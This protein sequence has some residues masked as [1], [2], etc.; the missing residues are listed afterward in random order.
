M[1]LAFVG[2]CLASDNGQIAWEHSP[3]K[4]FER[5]RTEKRCVILDLEAIWCHWCHV[6]DEKTYSDPR[7][8]KLLNEH[9]VALKVDQDS[10]P[11]FSNRYEEYGWPATILFGP[12]GKELVKRSGYIAPDDMVSLLEAIVRDPTPGP[13]AAPV[14]RIQYSGEGALSVDQ[15]RDLEEKHFARYDAKM[16]GWGTFHKFL[17]ADCVEYAMMR[18]AEGD[19]RSEKMARQTLDAQRKLIDPVWGGVYQYSTDGDWDHP[20]FEKIMSVQGDNLRIYAQAYAFWNEP[21]YLKAAQSIH[22]YLRDFM[23]SPDGVFYTSQD[24]DVVQGRHSGDYFKLG[25]QERRAQ[26]I[27]RIDTHVYA[28]ENGWAIQ[29]LCALYGATGDRTVRDEA[30]RAANW[31][32]AHRALPRGGFR[33]DAADASGPYLGDTLSM[34]QAM[35][36]LYTV[37]GDREWLKRAENAAVFISKHFRNGTDKNAAGFLAADPSTAKGV[38]PEPQLDENIRLVRFASLLHQNTGES[39]YQEMAKQGM[40]YLSTPAV[41]EKKFAMVAGFLLA[42]RELATE[43]V[44]VTVVGSKKDASA[45]ALFEAALKYPFVYRRIEWFDRRE[46]NPRRA[47]VEYPEFDEAAAFFCGQGRCSTP[48]FKVD[49][50]L[51]KIQHSLKR[52]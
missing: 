19:A 52:S 42:D 31:M 46:G 38:Q 15:R 9:F 1:W 22:R 3:D 24:A 44:H 11:D 4:A 18:A 17:N 29:G 13:S 50:L 5:A 41:I 40:R 20:H 51:A 39:A 26:G 2:F 8:A 12:D 16:G 35:L 32:M 6:M 14:A 36:A 45:Q 49:A 34:G 23:M 48:I 37:T 33:H 43:P 28:R 25:D 7:V 27:P 21:E 10:R 30:I 47:D